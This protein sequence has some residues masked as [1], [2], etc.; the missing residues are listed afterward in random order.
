MKSVLLFDAMIRMGN[1]LNLIC[2]IGN[3]NDMINNAFTVREF[4]NEPQCVVV[5]NAR[6]MSIRAK[7]YLKLLEQKCYH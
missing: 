4:R 2:S 6:I 1:I 3:M 5:K 7:E